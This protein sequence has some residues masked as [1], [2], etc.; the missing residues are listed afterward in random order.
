MSMQGA[1]NNFIEYL[2]RMINMQIVYQKK[3]DCIKN[4]FDFLDEDTILDYF[5][6]IVDIADEFKVIK[7]SS[8]GMSIGWILCFRKKI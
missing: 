5:S 4:L 1:V 2:N 7:N 6:D 8:V 3:L